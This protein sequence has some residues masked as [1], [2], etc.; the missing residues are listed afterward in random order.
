MSRWLNVF[1][2]KGATEAAI[3]WIGNDALLPRVRVGDFLHLLNKDRANFQGDSA[4]SARH[5]AGTL[6]GWPCPRGIYVGGAIIN[7]RR[8]MSACIFS[9]LVIH[10]EGFLHP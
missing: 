6:P 7:G 3:L 9:V 10:G 2:T 8:Y 1:E 4:V 5:K